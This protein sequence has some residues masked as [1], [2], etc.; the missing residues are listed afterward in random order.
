M[1]V[2]PAGGR[3]RLSRVGTGLGRSRPWCRSGVAAGS[4]RPIWHEDQEEP[5][6]AE[7]D[8]PGCGSAIALA[9]AHGCLWLIARRCCL[10]RC[11]WREMPARPISRGKPTFP[12]AHTTGFSTS[13]PSSQRPQ[14]S[15]EFLCLLRVRIEARMRFLPQPV[16]RHQRRS[17]SHPL[18]TFGV[19][20]QPRIRSVCGRFSSEWMSAFG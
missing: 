7:N 15:L 5:D 6:D 20:Q 16:V 4:V 9:G 10:I 18:R 11:S 13:F 19:V 12:I 2:I 3:A 8:Y 14:R 17:A 1:R